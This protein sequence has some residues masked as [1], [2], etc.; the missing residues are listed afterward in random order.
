[1]NKMLEI[2]KIYNGDC[3]EV[4]KNFPDN[5]IDCVVTSPPYW[6]CRDYGVEG[7]IGLEEHPQQYINKI[8]L[9]MKE[10]KR[11]IKE[12][13]TIWLNLGDSFYTKSGSGQGSNYLKRY[14]EMDGGRGELH[15]A[16]TQT[17]GK[18]KSN[19]LKNKQKLLIPCRI[20]IACQDELGLVLRN[21]IT[22]VKQVVN[23]KTKESLGSS[24]PSS[25]KDRL[26]LNS[27]NIFLF[28]KSNDYYFNLDAIRIKHKSTSI[29]RNKYPRLANTSK[30]GVS[31]GRPTNPGELLNPLGKN[32]G[33][34]IMF[35]LEPNSENHF[36][37]FPKT[38][39]EFC[40][41]AGCPE[42]VC[43]KCGKPKQF[44]NISC[45]CK[46]DF[47]GGIVLDPFSGGGTTLFVAKHLL[48]NYIGIEINPTY[49]KEIQN[50][51]LSQEI[52]KF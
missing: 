30:D 13:G 6:C 52:L 46:E 24:M 3:L 14:K 1:M 10:L 9:V 31:F 33:D 28:V 4:L 18:F 50:N 37:M 8:V 25:I 15:K 38:L 43:N 35:P 22:W 42:K 41:L 29:K 11:I 44:K 20:A 21:N 17:R 23:W 27:E 48:R 51:K 12:T 7:Q 39:P 26:N 16:Q 32:P 34:C 19:W 45:N 2:N 5:S 49:I 40:I 47:S 36:A